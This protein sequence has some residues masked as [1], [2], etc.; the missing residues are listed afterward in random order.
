MRTPDS[1]RASPPQTRSYNSHSIGRIERSR[2]KVAVRVRRSLAGARSLKPANRGQSQE[3]SAGRGSIQTQRE[4]LDRGRSSMRRST[5]FIAQVPNIRQRCESREPAAI[6]A[7]NTVHASASLTAC[8][9]RWPAANRS[10]HAGCAAIQTRRSTRS[11]ATQG[12]AAG[13]R[14]LCAPLQA[15][16]SPGG[17][18]TCDRKEPRL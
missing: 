13:E 11:Q 17:F 3:G 18:A 8:K 10:R 7:D 4:R 9:R 2:S 14:T 6:E 12:N 5:Y 1:S 16:V 15:N